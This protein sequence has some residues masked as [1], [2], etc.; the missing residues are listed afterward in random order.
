MA[1]SLPIFTENT[2]AYSLHKRC[3]AK[4]RLFFKFH[5]NM[6]IHRDRTWFYYCAPEV[7]VIEVRSDGQLVAYELKGVRH[8]RSGADY[9][10]Y[11]DA[12]G[13]GIAYLDLPWIYEDDQRKFDGGA[14]DSVYIVCARETSKVDDSETRILATVPIGGMIALPDGQLFT[15]KEAPRNPIQNTRAKEHFLQNLNSL[16]KHTTD[17]RIYRTIAEAGDKWF[18]RTPRSGPST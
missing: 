3:D 18:C 8:H 9:P 10:A 1:D 14:F 5:H 13:Q 7:D 4:S 17:S 12:I 16:D 2:V 6:R 11:N 15:V